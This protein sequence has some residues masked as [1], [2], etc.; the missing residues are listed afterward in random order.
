MRDGLLSVRDL[1]RR[2]KPR[3]EALAGSP[4]HQPVLIRV[5]RCFSWLEEME[6]TVDERG[7]AAADI[8]LVVR[9]IALNALYGVWD[10]VSLQPMGDRECLEGFCAKIREVDREG[11]VDKALR[12]WRR[13]AMDIFRD[14]Y[15][16]GHFWREPSRARASRP[17]RDAELAKNWYAANQLDR[18]LLRLLERIYFLRC[19]LVHGAASHGGRLNRTATRRCAIML[20]RLV[21]PILLVVVDHGW[22]EDWGRLCYPPLDGSEEHEGA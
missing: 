2:W 10:P 7:E 15:L 16:T 12:A 21:E 11:L 13:Q 3:K 14:A 18:V 8:A 9:W 19:Q 4:R 6:R 22:D 5:H 1:R 20:G 17:A